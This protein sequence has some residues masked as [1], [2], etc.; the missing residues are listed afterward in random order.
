MCHSDELWLYFQMATEV[1]NC[2]TFPVLWWGFL[3][4]L[5]EDEQL[6]HGQHPSFR[7][8]SLFLLAFPLGMLC[9]TS[10]ETSLNCWGL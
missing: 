7:P 1:Q 5:S 8:Q 6:P 9:E 3:E 4:G 2:W 10:G